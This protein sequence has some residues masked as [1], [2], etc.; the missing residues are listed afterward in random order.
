MPGRISRAEAIREATKKPSDH[1]DNGSQ[2]RVKNQRRRPNGQKHISTHEV[3]LHLSHRVY[4]EISPQKHVRQ[5]E[6]RCKGSIAQ[7]V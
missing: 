7:A 2:A 6:K 1:N 4:P 3:E 5:S